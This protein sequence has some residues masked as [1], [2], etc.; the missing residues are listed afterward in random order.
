MAGG[1]HHILTNKQTK[2][3]KPMPCSR[4][5]VPLKLS[6]CNRIDL[7]KQICLSRYCL[8][9]SEGKYKTDQNGNYSI[10]TI[11][12]G[13]LLPLVAA[14]CWYCIYMQY[15]FCAALLASLPLYRRQQQLIIFIYI[16]IYSAVLCSI[17]GDACHL[18]Y[19]LPRDQ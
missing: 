8:L 9:K 3:S 14:N 11:I 12:A 10:A 1:R 19:F 4:L 17:V 15:S 7:T 6:Q 18:C 13:L 16:Y 2:P 5:T